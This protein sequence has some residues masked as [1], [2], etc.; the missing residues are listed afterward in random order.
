MSGPGSGI[1][2]QGCGSGGTGGFGGRSGFGGVGT[3][4]GSGTGLGGCGTGSGSGGDGSGFGP[5]PGPGTGGV[6]RCGSRLES[7]FGV[8]TLPAGRPVL[9]SSGTASRPRFARDCVLAVIVFIVTG[10]PVPSGSCLLGAA[11]P[12]PATGRSARV[13]FDARRSGYQA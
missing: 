7:G 8:R 10:Y 2:G 13:G 5:G 1:G 11:G 6:L 4:P 3:G 9:R 12:G